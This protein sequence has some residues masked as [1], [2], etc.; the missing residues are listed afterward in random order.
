MSL[1]VRKRGILAAGVLLCLGGVCGL[2]IKR[3]PC[4]SLP[5]ALRV[6]LSDAASY[7]GPNKPDRIVRASVKIGEAVGMDL[8]RLVRISRRVPE[9]YRP[10]FYDGAAHGIPWPVDDLQDCF[11]SIEAS[12]PGK[13]RRYLYHGPIVR[14]VR[15]HGGDPAEVLPRLDELPAP[16]RSHVPNGLRI[17][18][19]L[20]HLPHWEKAIATIVEY[21][22]EYRATMFEEF[23]W[24]MGEDLKEDTVWVLDL[25]SQ[26]P[27]KFRDDACKGY[28]RG[29]NLLDDRAAYD[30]VIDSLGTAY[31][32]AATEA[33]ASKFRAWQ[34]DRQSE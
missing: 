3:Q 22:E 23:G 20:E 19:M 11:D 10:D 26:V 32:D 4:R 28:I 1:P 25:L 7:D 13:Y 30:N 8:D 18:V 31:R 17:G 34:A 21:P 5:P 33:L 24:W 12:V 6:L 15:V 29:L 2:L 27:E 16:M 14:L 9:Y